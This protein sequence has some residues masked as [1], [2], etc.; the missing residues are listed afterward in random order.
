MRGR[1]GCPTG[2]KKHSVGATG[3]SPLFS[4][5][6]GWVRDRP[7]I[8]PSVRTGAPSPQGEGF[9]GESA[10]GQ[11]R[12]Y[13]G[14]H[15]YPLIWKPSFAKMLASIFFSENAS[16][17]GLSI[18]EGIAPQTDQRQRSPNPASGNERPSKPG[19][20]GRSPGPLSPH[21]SGEMGTPAGQA[22]Q[23]GAAPRG[24]ETAPTTRRV[25]TTGDLAPGPT[26]GAAG[27]RSNP[28]KK[29]PPLWSATRGGIP[30]RRATLSS[31][32][33]YVCPGKAGRLA[34]CGGRGLTPAPA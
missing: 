4:T 5:R 20:Q 28:A 8:R 6:K 13:Y 18:P 34:L 16:Q 1:P 9:G 15:V 30:R 31:C 14:T 22:G 3:G 11:L 29:E 19:V 24:F 17:I 12:D 10:A 33:L 7:L 23:R 26:S 21:F 32:F 2:Q 27:R 25:R